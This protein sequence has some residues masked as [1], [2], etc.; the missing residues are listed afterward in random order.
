MSDYLDRARKALEVVEDLAHLDEHERTKWLA[1]GGSVGKTQQA[2]LV[3]AGV[4]AL[5]SIAEALERLVDEAG[6]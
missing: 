2:Y 5:V 3:H 1:A 4:L 6:K